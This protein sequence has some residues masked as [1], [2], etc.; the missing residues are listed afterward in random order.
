V[1]DVDPRFIEQV[2][3]PLYATLGKYHQYSFVG[4]ETIP[5][6][7]GVLGITSHGMATYELFL[8]A[9]AIYSATGRP[10]R[11]LG[12]AIWFRTPALASTFTKLGMVNTTPDIART[13]LDQGNL[14]AVAPGG[15]REALR[16]ATKRF[17]FDWEGRSG[18]ARLALEAQ[19]PI[20]LVTCPAVDLVYTLYDN[21]FTNFAYRQWKLPLPLMFGV[22]PT[23][24]P[25]PVKLTGYCHPPF[26]PP[27]IAGSRATD[28]E[29]QEYR[30]VLKAKMNAFM[31]EVCE[32][33]G[34][35]RSRQGHTR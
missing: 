22:G 23:L 32:K 15:A 10:V 19:K 13:L 7:G 26:L 34:L 5:R 8:T 33:E 2:F 1:V 28:E 6:E 29:V 25:R 16:P 24:I 9:Y 20:M 31:D 4:A 3:G 21:P 27:P 11:T 14:V 30:E 35:P 12:D 17:Q 18:F